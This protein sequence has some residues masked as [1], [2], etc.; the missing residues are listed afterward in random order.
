MKF[1]FVDEHRHLRPERMIRAVPGISASGYHAWRWHPGSQRGVENRAL[2]WVIQRI[3]AANSG[4]HGAPRVHAVLRAAGRRVGRNRVARLMC[5]GGP[6]GLAAIPPPG[7]DHGQPPRLSHRAE[8]AAPEFPD[9]RA[10]P[11]LAWPD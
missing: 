7:A 2:L 8:Q 9:V 4:C 3:H 6:R 11:D 10:E 1:G 5:L